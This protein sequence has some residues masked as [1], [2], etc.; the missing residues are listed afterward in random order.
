[1]KKTEKIIAAVLTMVVGILLI[2]MKDNFIAVLMSGI[3]LGFIVFG[4]VDIMDK[5]IPPA[6]VKLVGGLLV[7]LC[8]WL[9]VEAVLYLIS[10]IT[11]ICGILLLY[12]KIKGKDCG[13][14]WW[15]TLLVYTPASLCVAIGLFLL[16]HK[17]L[18]VNFI[19]IGCG[20]FAFIE[21]VVLLL[22][23]FLEEE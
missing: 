8:G 11:L 13:N 17:T 22:N 18:T 7:I 5:A 23:F 20:I 2:V 21:G 4:V 16:F 6:V 15:Q 19:F 1:M 9:V 10:A 14:T 12:D 3:G